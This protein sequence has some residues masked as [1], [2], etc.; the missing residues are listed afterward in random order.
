MQFGPLY[1][2]QGLPGG[3]LPC[4]P[5]SE[6]FSCPRL[7]ILSPPESDTFKGPAWGPL[8]GSNNKAL[9]VELETVVT[10]PPNEPPTVSALV[11]ELNARLDKVAAP[12]Y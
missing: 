12:L 2:A 11:V 8:N 3:R 1:N 10:C 4:S 6:P 7:L 9:W 5:K